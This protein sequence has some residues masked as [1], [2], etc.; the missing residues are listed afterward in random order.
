[1]APR[2]GAQGRFKALL[3][4]NTEA[5]FAAIRGQAFESYV[6]RNYRNLPTQL[7]HIRE[8]KI[9][10]EVKVIYPPLLSLSEQCVFDDVKELQE[11]EYGIPRSRS[12]AAVDAVVRPNW[13]F[14][15]S[16][17]FDHDFNIDGLKAVKKGLNLADNQVLHVV[18]VC[19]PDV[20]QQVK[21]QHLTRGKQRVKRP[22]GL[23]EGIGLRQYR[24]K[25]PWK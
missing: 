8:L 24:L 3:A 22:K 14:Q 5:V 16:V 25:F 18:M 7:K 4:N 17:S 10:G 20:E 11:N 1:M 12:Y 6:H 19:P 15:M 21:W 23:V 13:A 9:D 2:C